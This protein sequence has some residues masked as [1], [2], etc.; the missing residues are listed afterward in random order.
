MNYTPHPAARAAA[1]Q[2]TREQRDNIS[3]NRGDTVAALRDALLDPAEHTPV[4][5]TA[6]A[7]VLLAAHTRQLATAAREYAT[8]RNTKMREA[9]DRSRTAAVTGMNTIARLL[10]DRAT[11]LD[12]QPEADR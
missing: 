12:P 8:Q 5:A 6:A 2:A 9:G 10:N 7:H 4:S 11:L 1:E 3:F